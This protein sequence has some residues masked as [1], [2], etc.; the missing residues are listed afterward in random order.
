MK[1]NKEISDGIRKH[2]EEGCLCFLNGKV[3]IAPIELEDDDL[4]DYYNKQCECGRG[5][6][7]S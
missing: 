1:S 6:N 7:E 4:W 2:F 3:N 5:Y